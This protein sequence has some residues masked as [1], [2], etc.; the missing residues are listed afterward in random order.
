MCLDGHPL[1]EE[2]GEEEE[3]EGGFSAHFFIFAYV[4]VIAINPGH[5]HAE[6]LL[7]VCLVERCA[8]STVGGSVVEWGILGDLRSPVFSQQ[9]FTHSLQKVPQVQL[10]GKLPARFKP[11]RQNLEN[12][13]FVTRSQFRVNMIDRCTVAPSSH[14]NPHMYIQT[15]AFSLC[16]KF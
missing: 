3:E 6:Q 5:S 2:G 12:T 16:I 7:A 9:S 10:L 4:W 1:T 11:S 8:P 15:H 14:T 13:S